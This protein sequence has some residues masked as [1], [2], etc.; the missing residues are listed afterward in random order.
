MSLTGNN[1]N[2]TGLSDF[3]RTMDGRTAINNHFMVLTWLQPLFH[4]LFDFSNDR[5]RIF[6][7][8]CRRHGNQ[9]DKRRSV[10]SHFFHPRNTRFN[11]TALRPARQAQELI[12]AVNEM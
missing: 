5:I 1:D 2:I 10:F 7:A 4:T 6:R 12:P 11:S 9:H 3:H 8:S